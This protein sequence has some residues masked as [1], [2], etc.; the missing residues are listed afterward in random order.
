MAD[1]AI[2]DVGWDSVEDTLLGA[3]LMMVGGRPTGDPTARYEELLD[4]LRTN[5]L[6]FF[7]RIEGALE[8][9]DAGK[10]I[11]RSEG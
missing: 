11:A 7:A 1:R 10:L 9:R 6:D 2:D 5:P 8:M 3:L 4:L